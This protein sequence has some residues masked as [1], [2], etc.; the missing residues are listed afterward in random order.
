[1]SPEEELG[2]PEITVA[3]CTWNRSRL[4]QATLD[5]LTKCKIRDAFVWELLIIDNNSTDDT[6]AVAR[7]FEGKLPL[8]YIFEEIPGLSNAR[9]RALAEARSPVVVWTDDD[10]L[11]DAEW[12]A[13]A[14]RIARTKPNVACFGGPIR[15]WFPFNPPEAYLAAFPSL[16]SGFCGIDLGNEQR[17][18]QR[19]DTPFGANFALRLSRCGDLKFDPLLGPGPGRHGLGGDETSYIQELQKRGEEVLWVPSLV[20][21]HYVDPQ[22][23]KLSYLFPFEYAKGALSVRVGGIPEGRQ[24]YGVPIW[25]L[26]ET[27]TLL[28][29]SVV[30]WPFQRKVSLKAARIVA[31]RLG[32]ISECR[33][34]ALVARTLT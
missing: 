5:A 27:V 16:A 10:V 21:K 17:H 22:R 26:R 31:F 20:V 19:P 18:L 11:V 2:S 23:M 28:A 29:K 1:M 34:L 25:L 6:A 8:R 33:T 3:I 32:M 9:N 14:A 15:P 24:L 4:L 7:G 30:S 13:E 12:L